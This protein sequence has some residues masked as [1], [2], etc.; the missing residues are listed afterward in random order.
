MG[1]SIISDAQ[2]IVNYP[3]LD[4]LQ[5]T[6]E[7]YGSNAQGEIILL[8]HQARF[9]R[10]EYQ[11][12]AKKLSEMGDNCLAVDLRSGDQ[13]NG[14]SNETAS[15]A[16]TAGKPT[17]YLD[18]EQDILASLEYLK[19]L[20]PKQVI[21]VGSSYSAS[22]VLK[23]AKESGLVKAVISFSPGEYFGEK[24]KLA[25]AIKGLSKPAF[26][27]SSLKEAPAVKLLSQVIDNQKL[28]LFVPK[29]E[30]YHGSKAL[31]SQNPGNEE[32]WAA[33][34]VFLEKLH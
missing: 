2:K 34:K 31:W 21:L 25:S 24:L 14:I 17:E 19:T 33:L 4:G 6:A 11:E 30:G 15:R 3:S 27:T 1:I 32:Y 28:T 13:V 18:A 9:S 7:M 8:C 16:R 20:S 10:G 23:I 12:T 5:I 22:L 26:L 29:G